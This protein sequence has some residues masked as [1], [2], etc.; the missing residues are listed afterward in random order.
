MQTDRDS[1]ECYFSIW[2]RGK[3]ALVRLSS[4]YVE[5]TWICKFNTGTPYELKHGSRVI[6]RTVPFRDPNCTLKADGVDPTPPPS[7]MV[8]FRNAQGVFVPAISDRDEYQYWRI[9][10]AAGGTIGEPIKG[11]DSVR[12]CWKFADQIT[13]FRDYLDDA[14]GRRRNQCS[15]ELE[16][17]TLY[18]KVPWPRLEVKNRPTAMI[19]STQST[20]ELTQET[21]AVKPGKYCYSLQDVQFRI[22]TVERRG[23][24]DSDDYM[25]AG[26]NQ[27]SDETKV[28]VTLNDQIWPRPASGPLQVWG[29]IAAFGVEAGFG[30]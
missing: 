5:L 29:R 6:M 15:R 26:V 11:G 14:F 4:E 1:V 24:G 8:V 16:S 21:L 28:T 17:T 13:G 18:L 12:L 25:L 20:T 9:E 3:R 7:H 10:K 19:M 27:E 30:F 23:L 2:R 22:D